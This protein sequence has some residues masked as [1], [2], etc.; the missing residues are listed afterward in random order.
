MGNL[1]VLINNFKY[2]FD[3]SGGK[4]RMDVLYYALVYILMAFT[5][6]CS[7]TMFVLG[8]L[9]YSHVSLGG[10]STMVWVMACALFECNVMLTLA[11]EKNEFN[12]QSAALVLLM[13][14]TKTGLV[15]DEDQGTIMVNVTTAPGSSLAE[16]HKVMEQVSQRISG[17][18]RFA[19]T[20]RWQVTA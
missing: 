14:T 7:D 2:I 9:G 20:C 12:L 8:V 13:N 4:M 1:Y 17:I 3:P 19:T 15:P 6:V 18:P 11:Q 5:L 10:L 16:T